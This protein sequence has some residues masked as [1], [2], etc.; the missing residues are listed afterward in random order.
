MGGEA[1]RRMKRVYSATFPMYICAYRLQEG[2]EVVVVVA[3]LQVLERVL[4]RA[5]VVIFLHAVEHLL[6]HCEA[7]HGA[8]VGGIQLDG[9]VVVDD[10]L[11]VLLHLHRHLCHPRIDYLHPLVLLLQ[12]LLQH[13]HGILALVIHD[14]KLDLRHA[15]VEAVGVHLE[16]AV[17]ELLCLHAVGHLLLEVGERQE[18]QGDGAGGHL[19]A[20][21]LGSEEGLVMPAYE[22]VCADEARV[23]G[24]ALAVA[25][26][27]AEAVDCSLSALEL[28]LQLA[29]ESE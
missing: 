14:E 26:G 12:L 13:L 23:D 6:E 29:P 20:S 10:C 3:V 15:D 1:R 19:D 11:G 7:C 5:E 27:P 25:L 8:L 9:L 4:F 21:L 18:G 28:Q 24:K 2:V 22:V 17:D 16:G